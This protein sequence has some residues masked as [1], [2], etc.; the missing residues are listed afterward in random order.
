[1]N[2]VEYIPDNDLKDTVTSIWYHD[3]SHMQLSAY[4]IPFLNQEL[5]INYGD[6]F[7]VSSSPCKGYQYNKKGAISGIFHTPQKT[8]VAGRY[9]A[10]G[11]MLQPFGLYQLFGFPAS[12]FNDTPL[13]LNSIFGNNTSTLLNRLAACATPTDKI[14]QLEQCILQFATPCRIPSAVTTLMNDIT[15]DP[16]KKGR[17]QSFVAQTG[18]S[19]KSLIHAFHTVLGITPQKYLRMVQ[20]NQALRLITS[21]P[22]MPLTAVAYECGFYD[23]AHFIKTFKTLSGMSPSQYKKAFL[24][25]RVPR[26]FPNTIF[27]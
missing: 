1:M 19:H 3:A 24:Q 12:R 13:D 6:H 25:Q 21:T 10:I 18:K 11:I 4:N 8:T 7:E 20:L 26:L 17:I 22:D 2:K 23:Q 9:E 15:H 5:I 16:L 27:S 14:R